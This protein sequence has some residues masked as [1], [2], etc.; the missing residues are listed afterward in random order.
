MHVFLIPNDEDVLEVSEIIIEDFDAPEDYVFCLSRLYEGLVVHTEITYF[1]P[2]TNEFHASLFIQAL[3]NLIDYYTDICI[4]LFPNN[5]ENWQLYNL[6]I[7]E[8]KL[9][10]H[11]YTS[12]L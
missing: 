2:K 3:A 6:I 4:E 12:T 10:Q 1:N 9:I 5:A 7:D 11:E 8:L